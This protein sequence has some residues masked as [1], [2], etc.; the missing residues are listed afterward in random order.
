MAINFIKKVPS[1]D[2]IRFRFIAYAISAI[3]ILFSLATIFMNGLKY[4]VDFAGGVMVQVKFN[5]A[6]ED[7]SV[8]NALNPLQ[9]PGLIVQKFGEDNTEYLIRFSGDGNQDMRDPIIETLSKAI[10]NSEPTIQRLEMVGPKVGEDLKNSALEAMFYAVLLI[11]VYISGRFEHRWFLAGA[12][13]VGLGALVYVVGLLGLGRVWQVS[14]AMTLTLCVCYGIKLNFAFS[15]IIALLHDVLITLGILTFLGKE[16][17]LNIIAALLT[18]VG[19]S[20]NDTIVTFD[21]VRE[22]IQRQNLDIHEDMKSI[23]NGSINQTLSRTLLTSGTTLAAV[24]SLFVLGG[25]VIHDFAL[26]MLLGIIIGTFSSIFVA[27]PLLMALGDTK[28]YVSRL[29]KAT[30]EYEKPGE[31]GVV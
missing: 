29:Q 27:S 26:T 25:G 19:Y 2:F 13:A 18:L 12:M 20:L 21:R 23:L 8:K 1:I 17:D 6:V 5:Q 24:L 3:L 28:L 16:I 7:E 30:V 15:A 31:H 9:I 11:T 14:L 4:G 10:P 22:N